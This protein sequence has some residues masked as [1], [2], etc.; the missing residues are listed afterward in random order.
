VSRI[1]AAFALLVLV[2]QT[3][4]A[5]SAV[6]GTC[7][8]QQGDPLPDCV[9][10]NSCPQSGGGS[11]GSMPSGGGL[12]PAQQVFVNGM[13]Q[14]WGAML[15]NMMQPRPAPVAPAGPTLEQQQAQFQQQQLEYQRRQEAAQRQQEADRAAEERRQTD[16][17]ADHLKGQLQ[18][19]SGD[20]TELDLKHDPEA[21]PKAPMNS[22]SPA[23]ALDCAMAEVYE[24]AA[25]LGPGGRSFADGLRRDVAHAKRELKT[26][27]SDGAPNTCDIVD[28]SRDS[29]SE[30]VKGSSR[31]FVDARVTR[32]PGTGQTVVALVYSLSNGKKTGREGQDVIVLNSEGG[33][34]CRQATPAATKCAARFDPKSAGTDYC[35]K[36]PPEQTPPYPACGSARASAP[37][38]APESEASSVSGTPVDGGALK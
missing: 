7:R 15:H 38:P 32:I 13:G 3:A 26:I 12:T 18:M 33:V 34:D 29:M 11:G 14:I 25:S 1:L 21:P 23:L 2:A 35:P 6:S 22:K 31:L 36:P 28:F 16:E 4:R 17:M 19:D 30:G 37:A 27:P 10:S 9:C 20:G 8:T 5:Q 24:T